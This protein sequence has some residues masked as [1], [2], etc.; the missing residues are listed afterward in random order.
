M[1]G[2]R[3]NFPLGRSNATTSSM[4]RRSTMRMR[5]WYVL[6]AIATSACGG[7][8]APAE[9]VYGTLAYSQKSPEANFSPLKNYYLDPLMEV[10]LDGEKQP[11]VQVPDATK[12]VITNNITKY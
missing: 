5:R 2:T 11:S 1:M 12:P 6:A 9:V 7:Y 8:D 4:H 3:S 10:W